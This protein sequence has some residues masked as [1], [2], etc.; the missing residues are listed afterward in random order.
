[1]RPVCACHSTDRFYCWASRYNINGFDFE[2][3]IEDG[4][5]CDCACHYGDDEDDED[6]LVEAVT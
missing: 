1:M 3:I 5:P 6:G 4:G 2:A